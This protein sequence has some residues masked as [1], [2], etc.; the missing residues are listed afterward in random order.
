MSSKQNDTNIHLG[1]YEE[2]FIL[3]MDNELSDAQ[4]AEVDAFLALHPDLQAEFELLMNTRLPLEN[5]QI[6]KEALLSGAM[7]LEG[8][9]EE[10]LLFLDGELPSD[11]RKV[12]ELELDA[13]P[14]FRQ[15][16]DLLQKTKLDAAETVTFPDKASLYRHTERAG[17]FRPWMR[18]A[19]AVLLIGSLGALYLATNGEKTPDPVAQQ[20]GKGTDAARNTEQMIQPTNDTE[21]TITPVIGKP[22]ANPGEGQL[23]QAPVLSKK[24]D[25]P[26]P[27]VK[28]QEP[29]P[30]PEPD[31]DLIA[32]TD[33]HPG[34]GQDQQGQ[35]D[36]TQN[37]RANTGAIQT[38]AA[39]PLPVNGL[40]KIN[41]TSEP[42]I[43]NTVNDVAAA[44]PEKESSDGARGSVKGFLR[45]ATRLIEK[46]T[47][48]DPTNEDG[49]LLIGALAVKLK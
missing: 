23:A 14:H 20:P 38:I 17:L 43:R 21:T 1:N 22:T 15:E 29:N 2:F 32:Y 42:A 28:K 46:R 37:N 12:V 19:A 33:P 45:K 30:V 13:N 35:P 41:V 49:E 6:D 8:L 16:F 48:I 4:M 26:K 9:D 34:N 10:L 36:A 11:R 44:A 47:G 27:A 7:K 18:A 39:D 3:Y 24:G 31:Q 5:F 25:A 40:N